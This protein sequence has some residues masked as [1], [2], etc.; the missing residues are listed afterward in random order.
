MRRVLGLLLLLGSISAHGA[1]RGV[2]LSLQGSNTVGEKL[3]PALAIA[4]A[5]SEGWAVEARETPAP[6]EHTIRL[7]RDAEHASIRIAAHG[8]ST[9]LQALVDGSADLWMASRGVLAEEVR[10]H[11]GGIGRLDDP[12]QEHVIALDGLAIIVHPDS[13]LGTLTLPQLRG[14]FLGDIDD[15]SALGLR[16]GPIALYARDDKSGT[17]DTFRN[18]VLQGRA[19]SRHAR[20]FESTAALA[21]AVAADPRAIGFVG[22]AGVGTARAIAVADTETRPLLP[23]AMS[24]ATEDYLLSRRLLLYSTRSP[25]ADVQRFIEFAQSVQGQS[26][27]GSM[28]FVGQDL[29]LHA[30]APAEETPDVYRE[31][32]EGAQRLSV[33]LRFGN[34]RSFLDSKAM[35][36]LDRIAAFLNTYPRSEREITLIGFSDRREHNPVLALH[37]SN[38]RAD[39]VAS[40]LARRG[41]AVHRSRGLGQELAVAG[42]DSES[43]RSKNRRVEI[44]LRAQADDGA[45]LVRSAATAPAPHTGS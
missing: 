41:I 32:T 26:L 15:W 5:E 31:L 8:T 33:N 24:V 19:L 43:G 17:F 45:H 38:D 27:V 40:E 44:W 34:G 6:N 11:A 30:A 29:R 2:L 28:G 25:R 9:G 39:Y 13:R 3:A 20:R 14:I 21:A 23:A 42:N 35:R 10:A 4:W 22:L 36:D 12:A 1:E 18:L 37:M 16:A 7:R